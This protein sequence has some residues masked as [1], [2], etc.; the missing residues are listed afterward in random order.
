MKNSTLIILAALAAC[1]AT[2]DA[3]Q[4]RHARIHTAAPLAVGVGDRTQKHDVLGA[5][6]MLRRRAAAAKSTTA[7]KPQ[8][9]TESLYMDGE[10]M[11]AGVYTMSYD[12]KGR[13][14]RVDVETE[15]GLTRTDYTWTD[16]DQLDTQTESTS[17]DGGVTFVPSSKRV[18]TYDAILPAL[19][20]TKDK[21][22]WD[23]ESNQWVPNYDSF[24]RTIVRN[25]DNNVTSLALAVPLNGT[26]DET[27]RITNTFDPTTKQATSFYLEE[28]QWDGSWAQSQYLHD[29]VWKKTNG[30][31]VD[32]FDSWQT[33][34]NYLL[35]GT[36]GDYDK[37]TGTSQD[38]GFVK[39]VYDAQNG[40]TETIDYTDVLSKAVTTMKYT[41][42]KGS[43]VYDY[44]YYEDANEDGVLDDKD[45][46]EGTVL[47]TMY[48]ANGNV[49][50]DEQEDYGIGEDG[51]TYGKIGGSRY[52]YTY[53]PEHDNAM[54]TMQYEEY[55][56]D[57]QD[58]VPMSRIATTAFVDIAA[59]IDRV[60]TQ[61]TD[62]TSA[63]YTLQGVKTNAVAKGVYIVKRNGKFVKVMK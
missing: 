59:G 63:I 60:D 53:D 38:F 46:S 55:D 40:Y 5:M 1:S 44:K 49:V 29:L 31:L 7:Y 24:R 25:A 45:L 61:N 13:Q 54:L 9:Q 6:T 18:Q 37:T 10:W 22:D 14:T 33:Y 8:T 4:L 39:I 42:D 15:D 62:K 11:D 57:A 34:G 50:L 28:Q 30:Q 20:L 32:G 58:F 16:Q 26:F 12:T 47:T 48:D 43:F 36:I 17:E 51:V 3:Q 27:Q 35:S 2:A 19:T 52:V 23:A 21:Y 41:D 56:E